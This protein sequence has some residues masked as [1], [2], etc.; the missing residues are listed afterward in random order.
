MPSSA[1]SLYLEADTSRASAVE[2]DEQP[3]AARFA[4]VTGGA[5]RP[6]PLVVQLLLAQ[7]LLLLWLFLL[8]LFLLQLLLAQLL[9]LRLLPFPASC[10]EGWLEFA[11]FCCM[12]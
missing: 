5:G 10:H 2:E 7:L 12:T 11:Q 3:T 8:W 1:P 9:M 6:Q 4:G